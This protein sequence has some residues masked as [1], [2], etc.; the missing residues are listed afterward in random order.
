[1]RECPGGHELTRWRN[2]I[3]TLSCDG[4]CSRKLKEGDFDRGHEGM[5]LDDFVAQVVTW[6]SI[7]IVFG[8]QV[9]LLVPLTL[10]A[11]L[12][13]VWSHQLG[14]QRFGKR[15]ARANHAKPSARILGLS[16]V[17]QQVLAAAV[18]WELSG[19]VAVV[20]FSVLALLTLI[21]IR[22]IRKELKIQ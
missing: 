8:A 16:V 2:R 11:L 22:S 13:N 21:C 5:R 7:A 19:G 14:L 17:L 12:T 1:M 18:F 4:A 20:I 10:L 3:A 9:P 6:L 15:E